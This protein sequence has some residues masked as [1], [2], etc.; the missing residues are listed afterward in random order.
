M[1]PLEAKS[2][3]VLMRNGHTEATVDLMRLAGLKEIGLC[4]EIMRDDGTMMRTTELMEFAEKH[5]LKITSIRHYNLT[6]KCMINLWYES[7]PRIC[8]PNMVNLCFTVM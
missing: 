6:E 3:G 1:F 8:P 2:G 5:G 7:L 4:C